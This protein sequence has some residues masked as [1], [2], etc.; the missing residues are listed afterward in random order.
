MSDKHEQTVK[1]LPIKKIKE[2]YKEALERERMLMVMSKL[3]PDR[4]KVQYVESLWALI[5]ED[6]K[7]NTEAIL[8]WPDHLLRFW[9]VAVLEYEDR[10]KEL[11]KK[12]HDPNGIRVVGQS[13][14]CNKVEENSLKIV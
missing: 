12:Y 7:F 4:E 1:Y 5:L 14:D 10:K 2:I 11:L 13:L 9:L 6:N 8:S 3:A